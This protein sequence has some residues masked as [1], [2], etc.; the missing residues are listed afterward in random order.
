[1][2]GVLPVTAEADQLVLDFLGRVADLAQGQMSPQSRSRLIERLRRDIDEK[3]TERR[4]EQAAEIRQILLGMGTAEALVTVEANKDPLYKARL[5]A[6]RSGY[7]AASVFSPEVD[8]AVASM[9]TPESLMNP[10]SDRFGGSSSRGEALSGPELPLDPDP[11]VAGRVDWPG[12]DPS[13]T[14]TMPVFDGGGPQVPMEGGAGRLTPAMPTGSFSPQLGS[15]RSVRGM[16]RVGQS[17]AQN[18]TQAFVSIALLA[19]GALMNAAMSTPYSV[20]AVILGYLLGM[21]SYSY[22]SSEKR[23]AMMGVPTGALLFYAFGLFLARGR[24]TGHTQPVDV[25]GTWQAAKDW[26]ATVPTMLGL[27]AALY[28]AWRLA[29]AIAKAG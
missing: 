16:Q 22:T 18:H 2:E 23:F 19:L 20:G 11:F 28:L 17:A 5:Q 25:S 7:G 10:P 1:M 26:F 29:R 6:Q 8:P 24:S 27:L 15:A 14:L 13:D 9:V 21:T 12:G 3:A 4:A